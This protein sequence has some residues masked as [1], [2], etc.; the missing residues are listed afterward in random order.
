[1]FISEQLILNNKVWNDEMNKLAKCI[2]P[3]EPHI[4]NKLN[5]LNSCK[6]DLEAVSGKQRR[7]N[8]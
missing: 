4:I 8:P 5:W 6:K 1:M 2:E 7:F 3:L